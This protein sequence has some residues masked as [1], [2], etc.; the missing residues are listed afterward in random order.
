[1]PHCGALSVC[2]GLIGGGIGSSTAGFGLAGA[3]VIVSLTVRPFVGVDFP[4][5]G[6]L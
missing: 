6:S 5:C 1:M 4:N 3:S 2:S